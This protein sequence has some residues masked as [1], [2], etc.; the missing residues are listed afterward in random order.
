MI[1]AS[2]CAGAL[3]SR[4]NWMT[5]CLMYRSKCD[6]QDILMSFWWAFL[7]WL[8]QSTCV[9]SIAVVEAT[10]CSSQAG[11]KAHFRKW[12]NFRDKNKCYMR[13][14]RMYTFHNFFLVLVVQ[15]KMWHS[16]IP[17]RVYVFLWSFVG[18]FLLFSHLS[19][20]R[21]KCGYFWEVVDRLGVSWQF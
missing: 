2:R 16:F 1:C 4:L 21:V 5:S 7:V 14:W 9:H 8:F 19:S 6:L 11:A 17:Y 12:A 20:V 18:V 3:P 13:Q 15:M 10:R